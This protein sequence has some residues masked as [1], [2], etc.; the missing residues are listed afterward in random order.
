MHK[1]YEPQIR[2]RIGT[3]AHFCEVVVLKFTPVPHTAAAAAA[4]FEVP[5]VP[6]AR[7]S[8][9]GRRL[10]DGKLRD[11]KRHLLRDWRLSRTLA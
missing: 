6:A 4:A 10:E 2:A 5:A 1:V 9:V 3:A 8:A 11:R 7:V